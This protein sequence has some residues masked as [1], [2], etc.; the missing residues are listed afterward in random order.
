MSSLEV[1]HHAQHRA[2]LLAGHALVVKGPHQ[3]RP[4]RTGVP[5]G[6]VT[7]TSTSLQ[8]HL[9]ERPA[10]QG[11]DLANLDARCAYVRHEHRETTV[12]HGA[13]L[14]ANGKVDPVGQ[15]CAGGP[16]L[17]A[18][19][20]PAVAVAL[21]PVRREARSDPASGSEKPWQNTSS[22]AAISGSSLR[23]GPAR[24]TAAWRCRSSS[25]T[26]DSPTAGASGSRSAP[27]PPRCASARAR[28]RPGRRASAA[29][30][31][32]PVPWPS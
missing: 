19:D 31:N 1:V 12:R 7:G 32:P 25:P 24:R 5:D 8:E 16:D 21:G 30:S 10:A 29:R 15:L 26:A 28:A 9:A 18:V 6:L 2:E 11:L 23:A 17:V 14:A 20:D 27:R 3:H 22:P 13:I 4:A